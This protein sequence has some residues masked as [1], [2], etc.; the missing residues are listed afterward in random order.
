MLSDYNQLVSAIK[1]AGV[2]AMKAA[3]PTSVCFG[4]VQSVSPLS[5]LVDSKLLLGANQLCMTRTAQGF[6]TGY[7]SGGSGEKSFA[8]HAHGISGIAAG[9]KVVLLQME[10]GQMYIILDKVV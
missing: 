3:A 2:E 4:I 5:V 8:S 6:S 1:K 9:D 7:T 10:G